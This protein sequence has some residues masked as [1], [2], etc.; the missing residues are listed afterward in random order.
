MDAA[1]A[2]ATGRAALQVG[3]WADACAAFETAL[4]QDEAPEALTG[5][6]DALRWLGETRRSVG[7][8]ERAHALFRQRGDA[9][10]AAY[11]CIDLCIDY[12]MSLGNHAAAQGWLARAERLMEDAAARPLQGWVWLC[13]SA[14]AS[15]E[16]ESRDL[17]ERA[18]AFG[19]ETGDHDLEW[20][21]LSTLGVML[22]AYGDVK[23]GLRCVDEAMA[24]VLSGDRNDLGTVVYA[25]CQMLTLCDLVFDLQRAQL[26]CRAADEF[27][28]T[29]GV[30]FLYA[31][32]HTLYGRVLLA[33]GRWAEA[34]RELAKAL[35]N[36]QD[37]YPAVH[38]LAAA[39][40]AE[41][42]IRQ[43]RLDDAEALL[44]PIQ[45]PFAT[46]V[47]EAAIQIRRGES[48]RAAA[49][50]TRWLRSVSASPVTAIPVLAL[51]L[52]AQI[53]SGDLDAA[54]QT[55]GRIVEA[56]AADGHVARAHGQLAHA[57]LLRAQGQSDQ[58]VATLDEAIRGF[59]A[60]DLPFETALARLELARA[61]A[62]SQ[63]DIAIVEAR[64]ALATLDRL[65]AAE[66]DSVAALLRSWGIGGRTGPRDVGVLSRREQEVLALVAAGLS[67]QQIAERLYITRKTAAHH[68]SN[69]LSK[70][71]VRNRA[72]AAAFAGR[73]QREAAG[74]L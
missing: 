24:G 21:A 7:L 60:V 74:R 3:R 2:I 16:G 12:G 40:L 22:A 72:E 59:V 45:D 37:E 70:L 19:R 44:A 14:H 39:G 26:W 67:N 43:G 53:A 62:D 54:A 61:L 23:G 5:L 65:G 57:R 56:D 71:G 36:T 52:E 42:W 46:V 48:A 51:L 31:K 50:L 4:A 27:V 58:A 20:C 28:S 41:L 63:R 47:P 69:V 34:E 64:G 9:F 35:A 17:V 10:A 66:A 25:S 6:A 73:A 38:A 11:Q 18:L 49:M 33:A 1:G 29:Y 13:R 15:S 32:C 68:V 55:A 30:P 8:R